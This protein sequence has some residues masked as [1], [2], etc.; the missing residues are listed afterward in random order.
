MVRQVSMRLKQEGLELA[1]LGFATRVKKIMEENGINEDQI[2]PIIQDFAAYCLKHNVSYD[3]VI[4]SGREALYLEQKFG[5]PVERIPESIIQAK[6]RIDRLEDQRLEILGQ[7]QQAR[8][9][10]DTILQDRDTVLAELEKYRK[11][12]YRKEIPSIKRIKNLK[13]NFYII[14]FHCSY[15]Y[16]VLLNTPKSIISVLHDDITHNIIF[17]CCI[18]LYVPQP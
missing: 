11:E 17:N 9:E 5:I 2:E 15:L 8:E 1:L 10:L 4:Q 13:S 7:K 16:C 14:L 12:K 6:K 18:I 3:T